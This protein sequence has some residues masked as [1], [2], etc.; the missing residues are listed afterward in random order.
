[1][2]QDASDTSVG[3][4]LSSGTSGNAHSDRGGFGEHIIRNDGDAVS[5]SGDR[6][7]SL[8][9]PGA[10]KRMCVFRVND[11]A[12]EEMVSGGR[13]REEPSDMAHAQGILARRAYASATCV[14]YM[15]YLDLGWM[16]PPALPT[17]AEMKRTASE[18]LK[19]S[20]S[21][22]ARRG[23]RHSTEVLR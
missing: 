23:K 4:R 22:C 12:E 3:R 10:G 9:V 20:E 11:K 19:V 7:L 13:E 8:L 15:H 17:A 16:P 14:V 5:K 18:N 1:V 6:Q 21:R 2:V